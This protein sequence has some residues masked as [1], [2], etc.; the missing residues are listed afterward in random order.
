MTLGLMNISELNGRIQIIKRQDNTDEASNKTSFVNL[1]NFS[2]EI[3]K[4]EKESLKILST[5]KGVIG[6]NLYKELEN[7]IITKNFNLNEIVTKYYS[8]LEDCKNLDDVAKTFPEIYLPKVS[9]KSILT[10]MISEHIPRSKMIELQNL[11]KNGNEDKIDEF[12]DSIFSTQLKES[13]FFE[14]IKILLKEIKADIISG[15]FKPNDLHYNPPK[16]GSGKGLNTVAKLYNDNFEEIILE[17]LKRNYIKRENSSDIVIYS[18][19]GVK[20]T[21]LLLRKQDYI[22]T[23]INKN[24]LSQLNS[25]ES[26]ALNIINSNLKT[27]EEFI[28]SALR[29]AWKAGNLKNEWHGIAKHW[30]VLRP[31]WAKNTGSKFGSYSTERLIDAYL[32]NKYVCG[33]RDVVESNPFAKFVDGSPMNEKKKKCIEFLYSTARTKYMENFNHIKELDDFK[34]FKAQFDLEGMAK[35][36]EELEQHYQKA[37]LKIFWKQ[38]DRR[39]TFSNALKEEFANICEIIEITDELLEQASGIMI[40]EEQKDE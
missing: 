19:N 14:N 24:L 29:N 23:L 9:P 11:A 7:A 33:H 22:F 35:S 25:M 40:S 30:K 15:E 4:L 6:E 34:V 17:I 38:Q 3:T 20:V 36:I 12:L 32:V 31:I 8:R 27:Q 5:Y 13:K 18:S 2:K 28:S 37:F 10:S 21:P 16:I 39:E 26:K 1:N